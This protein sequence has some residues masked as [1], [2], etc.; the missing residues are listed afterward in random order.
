MAQR[1]ALAKALKQADTIVRWRA[2]EE[3]G[4]SIEVD[5]MIRQ[6]LNG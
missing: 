4:Y 1:H 2:E 5:A 3:R 6:T